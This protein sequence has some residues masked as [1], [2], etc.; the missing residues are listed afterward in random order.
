[1]RK[2]SFIHVKELIAQ[3]AE[4]RLMAGLD[5]PIPKLDPGH[6]QV[7][8]PGDLEGS[9]WRAVFAD[10]IFEHVMKDREACMRE[11]DHGE[12]RRFELRDDA[13]VRAWWKWLQRQTSSLA[14]WEH[15]WASLRTSAHPD[16][17]H[18]VTDRFWHAT[19]ARK[20]IF[21]EQNRMGTGPSAYKYNVEL[22][23]T[24]AGDDVHVLFGFK[25]PI[26]LRRIGEQRPLTGAR[27]KKYNFIGPCYLHGVMDGE[28][29]MDGNVAVEEILLC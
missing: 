29:S 11:R 24:Q 20:M 13:K 25:L 21:T 28:I 17:F 3:L 22:A 14:W 23:D 10:A 1:M 7:S 18:F 9:F 6:N 27:E 15:Q 5:S 2:K 12:M 26:I 4:W 16:G 19:E 8:E